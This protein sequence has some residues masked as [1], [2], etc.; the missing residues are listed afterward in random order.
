[1][2]AGERGCRLT[3]LLAGSDI[4]VSRPGGG[5]RSVRMGVAQSTPRALDRDVPGGKN[6]TL[7]V[8]VCEENRD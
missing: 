2:P 7:T 5:V 1:M 4:T 3:T 6:E 8:F